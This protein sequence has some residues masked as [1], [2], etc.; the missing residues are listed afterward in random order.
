MIDDARARKRLTR[1]PGPGLV[2]G[3]LSLA[4]LTG[5][6]MQTIIVPI[7]SELPEYLDAPRSDTAW[8][9]TIT[10]LS[11]AVVTPIAGRLGD[12]FGKRRMA[13]IMLATM[14]IGSVI[15]AVGTGILW[16]IVGRGLQGAG[17]AVIPLG[18]SIMRDVLPERRLGGGVALMSATMGIG[19]SIG[20]PLSAVVS[21]NADWHLLFWIA[22]GL[23]ALC[24]ALIITIVPVSV[25]RT[26][27]R[28]DWVGAFGLGIG[29]SAVLLAV[30]RG[31][32]WGWASAPTLGVGGG[33]VAMLLAWG[34]YELRDRNP[35]VDLRVAARP[36]VLLTNLA[37]MLLSFGMFVSNIVL[38]QYLELPVGY[39]L[40]LSLLE[41]SLYLLP[42]GLTM[43]VLAPVSGRLMSV[44][45]PKTVL[46]AGAV[47]VGASYLICLV[48]LST[49][50]MA[51]LANLTIGV[52]LSFAFAAMPTLIMRAVPVTE[53]AAA[54]GLNSVMRSAGTTTASA[55]VGAVLASLS[56]P[57]DGVEMPTPDAFQ[58]SYTLGLVAAAAAALLA[59]LIPRRSPHPVGEHP[60]LPES[61]RR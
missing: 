46:V 43:L 7:Q 56:V 31:N 47:I 58:L 27:G 29:I 48:D 8:V 45:G 28:F 38:P 3:A 22:A 23:G 9:V 17:M 26:A 1:T 52:G 44:V 13:L 50:W 25:L 21:E 19:G 53:T 14:T 20:M 2:V 57:L 54:N 40:G 34:A 35:L 30:S 61:P 36:A 15:A 42:A 24:W 12:M 51:M 60:A 49:P 11:S 39:G 18:I 10:L 16:L 55:V 6:F 5:S 33:G 4:G 59:M 37:S 41:T 32:E